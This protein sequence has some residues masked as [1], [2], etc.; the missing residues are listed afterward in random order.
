MD[1][2]LPWLKKHFPMATP[3]DILKAVEIMD[4]HGR[5]A[6]S[7]KE[8]W[9]AAKAAVDAIEAERAALLAPTTERY[10][11]ACERLELIEADCPE[12]IGRCEGCTD[13]IWKGERYS[14]DS[15]GGVTLCE[16]CA[17][18]YADML[19]EPQFF[20]DGEG[21]TMTPEQAKAICDAHLAAGGSLDDKM[22]SA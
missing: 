10:D 7:T 8:E 3:H 5:H 9:K 13:P 18:S 12:L 1:A 16:E 14:Y 2:M 17:P 6:A 21:E 15:E 22:V 19:A 4:N 20:Y 11:A